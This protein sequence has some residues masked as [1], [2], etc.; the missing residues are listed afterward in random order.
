MRYEKL[1]NCNE[2]ANAE[3]IMKREQFERKMKT[4]KKA[5]N[6]LKVDSEFK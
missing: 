4:I 6:G 2:L 5:L 1:G 3:S